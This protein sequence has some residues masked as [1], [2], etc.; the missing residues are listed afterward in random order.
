MIGQLEVE[1]GKGRSGAM[2]VKDQLQEIQAQVV[3]AFA[4]RISLV[5]H[6][7]DLE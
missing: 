4:G 2:K 1:L 6:C 7:V 3:G 5:W